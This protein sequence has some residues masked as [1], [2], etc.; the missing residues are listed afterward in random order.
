MTAFRGQ[1]GAAAIL[2]GGTVVIGLLKV[3]AGDAAGASP[4]L[5]MGVA[6]LTLG[7][8]ARIW[9]RRRWLGAVQGGRPGTMAA[10]RLLRGPTGW[11][12]RGWLGLEADGRPRD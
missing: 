3:G 9:M 10:D 12:W 6:V 11:F 1:V 7:V 2:G 8:G 4:F 5:S